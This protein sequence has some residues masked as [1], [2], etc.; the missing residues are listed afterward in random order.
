MIFIRSV[1]PLLWSW[2]RVICLSYDLRW[3][4]CPCVPF[5]LRTTR[6]PNLC[7]IT[8]HICLSRELC[9]YPCLCFLSFLYYALRKIQT[10]IYLSFSLLRA[11]HHLSFDISFLSLFLPLFLSYPPRLSF[12]RARVTNGISII[13]RSRTQKITSSANMCVP[14]P[15]PYNLIC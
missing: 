15:L 6:D 2:F 1:P 7:L 9:C 10:L 4:P 8:H 13:Y 12:S 5:L 14:P 11:T 3:Y